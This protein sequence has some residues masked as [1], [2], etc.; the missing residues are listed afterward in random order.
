MMTQGLHHVRMILIP[1]ILLDLWVAI[2]LA[3]TKIVAHLRS[4]S[5]IVIF[6]G[7]IVSALVLQLIMMIA[8]IICLTPNKRPR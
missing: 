8:K 2:S 7:I 6:L 5:A 1:V 3:C 4:R